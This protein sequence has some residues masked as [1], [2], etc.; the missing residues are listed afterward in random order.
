MD[1]PTRKTRAM[2]IRCAALVGLLVCSPLQ[3]DMVGDARHHV[4][5][6]RYAEALAL[7]ETLL[8]QRPDDTDLLLEAARV[9]GWNDRHA[10]AIELYRRVLELAPHRVGDVRLALAWQLLWAGQAQEAQR[11]FAAETDAHAGKPEAW[12]GLAEAAVASNHLDTALDAYRR[13]LRLDPGDM[14]ATL[15]EARVLQWLGRDREAVEAY[16]RI[17]VQRPD[18]R[19]ARLRIARSYNALGHHQRAATL[20]AREVTPASAPD[21]R[22]EYARALR[23]A[24]LDNRALT[25]IE[26]LETTGARDLRGQLQSDLAD[27]VSFSTGYSSDSDELESYTTS[28]ATRIRIG[29]TRELGLSARRARL[30]QHANHISG[31][32]YMLN[33]GGRVGSHDSGYGI[34]WPRVE[35]GERRFAGWHTTAWKISAKWLPADLWR[36]DLEAGNDII[37]NIQSIRNRVR[38][39]YAS[40]GFDYRFAP[41]WL[42]SGGLMSLNFDDANRRTRASGRIEYL[43]LTDPRLT[44]GIEAMGFNDSAPPSPNRG[45]YSPDR[46]REIK[47]AATVE[48]HAGGW[49][50]YFK[51]A[52]G[53]LTESPGSGSTLYTLEAAASR[54][55]GSQGTLR[56]N[57]SRSDSASVFTKTQGGYVRNHFG[58][59]LEFRF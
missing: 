56:L 22:V 52:L 41:R 37:E 55:L 53:R 58:A 27:R 13:L 23:W 44:L 1:N 32:T 15:G 34:L 50:L 31:T 39:D 57:A 25:T 46:Y 4:E 24:G 59:A 49:D 40:A 8:Q 38:F 36:V 10:R 11:M 5:A 18:H 2:N 48:K 20:L 43:T 9:T 19:E 51:G 26:G 35:L 16:E 12:H 29:E 6:Q 33:Y 21:D 42:A 47:F 14:K 3:A 45:Y 54:P 17:L 28:I 30:D 7:Y